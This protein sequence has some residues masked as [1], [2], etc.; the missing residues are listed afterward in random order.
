MNAQPKSSLLGKTKAEALRELL[1][2]MNSLNDTVIEFNKKYIA[3]SL[4]L[5]NYF[6]KQENSG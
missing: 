4:K 2:D 3:L 5:A 1:I 6:Q